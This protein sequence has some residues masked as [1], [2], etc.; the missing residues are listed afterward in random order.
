[1]I[2]LK[3]FVFYFMRSKDIPK[4]VKLLSRYNKPISVTL[5]NSI[6]LTA[7]DINCLSKLTR[8]TNIT[9]DNDFSEKNILG[10]SR[11]TDLQSLNF[12]RAA[13]LPNVY[14]PLAQLTR[15]DIPSLEVAEKV[16]GNK[17][18]LVD[19]ALSDVPFNFGLK[20]PNLSR[21]TSLSIFVTPSEQ[22]G[23]HSSKML[24]PAINLQ[25]LSIFYSG[26]WEEQAHLSSKV[27]LSLRTLTALD[28]LKFC[29]ML[30]VLKDEIHQRTTLTYLDVF[31]QNWSAE[32]TNKWTSLV[33]LKSLWIK[34]R[35]GFSLDVQDDYNFLTALTNLADLI[36]DDDR[37]IPSRCL[38][39][40]SDTVTHLDANL[41][42]EFVVEGITRL[43]NLEVLKLQAY[44]GSP[45]VNYDFFTSLAH[46]TRLD[47]AESLS[48]NTSMLH[49]LH[50]TQLKVLNLC[51]PGNIS[52]LNLSKLPNLES[53]QLTATYEGDFSSISKNLTALLLQFEKVQIGA[54][55][56]L[57]L[58]VLSVHNA[59]GNEFWQRLSRLTALES[60]GIS[61]EVSDNKP[62]IDVQ[63]ARIK[64]LTALPCL[65]ELK[66]YQCAPKLKFKFISLLTNLQ[67][68]TIPLA[69]NFEQVRTNA[70]KKLRYLHA[71]E[72][73]F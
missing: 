47:I 35:T 11:L 66:I 50:L 58:K 42:K 45:P 26:S 14:S 39:L 7:K 53:L 37:R 29:D 63:E 73:C 59:Q 13:D 10:L 27:P 38:T 69:A 24:E 25:K 49:L 62:S 65:K 33:N 28:R 46:L 9:V 67:R 64:S 5:S 12:R 51:S 41:S 40:V 52:S 31:E 22:L 30:N 15:L 4:M 43:V 8:L 60:L 17:T 54:I 68:L 70:Q 20:I 19:L 48:Y 56:H 61:L 36:V 21:L 18:N 55:E 6:Q 44:S 23:E 2:D 32:V 34:L 3:D 57:P 1:M 71:C 16:I 72:F